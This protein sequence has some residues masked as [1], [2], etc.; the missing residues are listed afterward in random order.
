MQVRHADTVN[1]KDFGAA[2]NGI[3]DDTTAFQAAVNA[4]PSNGGVIFVPRSA[5]GYKVT[6]ASLSLGT[7]SVIWEDDGAA[8][9]SGHPGTKI[10][11]VKS[12]DL[13]S[14]NSPV[15]I[16]NNVAAGQYSRPSA[17]IFIRNR[18][19]LPGEHD[20]VGIASHQVALA[21]RSLT[22]GSSGFDMWS[23]WG[24]INNTAVGRHVNGVVMEANFTNKDQNYFDVTPENNTSG[25][26]YMY[27]FQIRPD[28]AD[29]HGSRAISVSASDGSGAWDTGV[30]IKGYVTR[31]LFLDSQITWQDIPTNSIPAKRYAIEFGSHVATA[32]MLTD[33]G[34]THRLSFVRSGSGSSTVWQYKNEGNGNV[35][36][37]VGASGVGF[38]GTTP[39]AQQS[40][41]DLTSVIT[42]L[43]SYGLS[44]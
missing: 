44:S 15:F 21:T 40:A 16:E 9:V 39:V 1:V 14:Y 27:G 7:K 25:T 23:F 24:L 43:K 35:L 42:L 36:L 18:L 41:S 4:L 13:T 2:G 34:G 37:Q 5:G 32:M 12:D 20:V 11:F 17:A 8:L 22:P 29:F 30:S 10:S 26:Y 31:G 19:A 33:D 38:F 6:T 3:T 28:Q